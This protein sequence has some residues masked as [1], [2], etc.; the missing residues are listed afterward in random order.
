MGNFLTNIKKN[1]CDH[2][3]YKDELKDLNSENQLIGWC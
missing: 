1:C 2:R 3:P